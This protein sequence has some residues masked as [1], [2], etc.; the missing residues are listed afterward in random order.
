MKRHGATRLFCEGAMMNAAQAHHL[1]EAGLMMRTLA[2]EIGLENLSLVTPT[3]L[4]KYLTGDGRSPKEHKTCR[5][6]LK[7]GKI[8][9]PCVTCGAKELHNIEFE[10]DAGKDK[11]HSWGLAMYGK[12]VIAGKII[13]V[14]PARRGKGVAKV[15]H[16]AAVAKKKAKAKAK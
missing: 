2:D 11:L 15:K 1:Y 10:K 5:K 8:G 7:S 6:V 13:H 16:R 12:D 9:P 14:E 3:A 4:K